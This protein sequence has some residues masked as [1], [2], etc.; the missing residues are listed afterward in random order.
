MSETIQR[1][2]LYQEVAERLERLILSGELRVGD[3]LPSERALM[4]RFGVGRPAV[5]EALLALE[6]AGLIA[7][8]GGE[9]ARVV[10]P[11]PAGMV[12]GLDAAVRHWLAE[13]AGVRHLQDARKLLE[14][15]LAREAAEIASPTDIERLRRAL[16]ENGAARGRPPEFERTDVAFHY[17]I[18]EIARNPIFTAVFQ[19]MTGWLTEQRTTTLRLAG[20]AEHAYDCHCRIFAAIAAHDPEAAGREMR[21]HLEDVAERYRRSTEAGSAA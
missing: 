20:T 1:R 4:E 6:R 2:R 7:I 18:A 16:A 9:R 21:R 12:A 19:A 14:V 3:A 5:R 11:T 15:G 13:P 8:A 10:R 17:V